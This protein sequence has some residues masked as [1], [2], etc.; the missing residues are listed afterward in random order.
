MQFEARLNFVK[1]WILIEPR[2]FFNEK[3]LKLVWE[4]TEEE[5]YVIDYRLFRSCAWSETENKK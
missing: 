2:E 1:E 5:A 4:K 3:L